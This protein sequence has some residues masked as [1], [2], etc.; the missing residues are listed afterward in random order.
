ME[1]IVVVEITDGVSN[2]YEGPEETEVLVIDWDLIDRDPG[3][4][5]RLT[6]LLEGSLGSLMPDHQFD[7]LLYALKSAVRRV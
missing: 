1:N 2:V 3:E 4:A 7:G 6:G 5:A